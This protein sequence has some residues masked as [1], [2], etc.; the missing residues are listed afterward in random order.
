MSVA[1]EEEELVD[2]DEQCSRVEVVGDG[3]KVDPAVGG[4][5]DAA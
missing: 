1:A 2:V 4:G 3:A 5:D